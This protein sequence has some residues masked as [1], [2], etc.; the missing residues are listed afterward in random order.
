MDPRLIRLYESGAAGDEVAAILRLG[1]SGVLP[2]GVRAVS[3]FGDIVTVRLRRGAIPPVHAAVASLKPAAPVRREPLSGDGSEKRTRML[4]GDFRRP[5]DDPATGR[6]VVLAS[7][8]WGLDFA[9][10]DFRNP[11]GSTRLLALW[12]QGADGPATGPFGYGRI[13][14]PADINR[15]LAS[16]NAYRTLGYDPS[17]SDIDG[18]GTHGTHVLGIAAGNDRAGGPMGVAPGADLVFVH[19]TTLQQPER[20]VELADSATILEAVDFVR[21]VAGPRPWVINLSMGQTGDQHD[22]TTLTEQGLDAALLEAPGRAITQSTGNYWASGLHHSGRVAPGGRDEVRFS[23]PEDSGAEL[24]VWYRGSDRLLMQLYA[25]GG[26]RAAAAGPGQQSA[27]LA[28]G[29]SVGRIYHR[30]GDPNNSDNHIVVFVDRDAPAGNWTLALSSLHAA[31]GRY[32][33][34]IQRSDDA[35]PSTRFA[36]NDTDPCFTTGSICNGR[37]TIATGAYDAHTDG[38]PLG[39]FSSSGP[40]R[41][42]RPK[43]DLVAPG[44]S[45]L[46]ARSAPDAEAAGRGALVRMSGTSMAAPHVAGTIALMFEAAPRPLRI[47]ETRELLLSAVRTPGLAT[48]RH[49]RGYLNTDEAVRAARRVRGIGMPVSQS[50]SSYQAGPLAVADQL[51][52]LGGAYAASPEALVGSV[53]AGTAGSRSMDELARRSLLSPAALFDSFTTPA[54]AAARPHLTRVFSTVAYPRQR[55]GNPRAGDLLVRRALGEPGVGHIAFV[56]GHRGYSRDEAYRRGMRLE[57]TRPGIYVHVVEAGAY[58]HRFGDRFA[59]RIASP[60]GYVPADTLLL[61]VAAPGGRQ[62]YREADLANAPAIDVNQAVQANDQYAT[63]LGWDSAKGRIDTLLGLSSTAGDSDLARGVA[64][65]QSDHSLNVD[66]ILGPDT[67]TAMQPQLD[68]GNGGAPVAVAQAPPAPPQQQAPVQAPPPQQPAPAQ[69]APAQPG[70]APA[71]APPVARA[72][73]VRQDGMDVAGGRNGN[74]MPAWADIRAAGITFLIHRSSHSQFGIDPDFSARYRDTASNGFIRGSYRYYMHDDAQTGLDQANVVVGLVPRL[75]PGDLA[76]SLDFEGDAL[77]PGSTEPS[78]TDWRTELEAFLDTLETKLGRTPIVYTRVGPWTQHLSGKPDFVAGDFAHFGDYPLWAPMFGMH[79]VNRNFTVTDAAGAAHVFNVRLNPDTAPVETEPDIAIAGAL[80]H[81]L[82]RQAS[83]GWVTEVR[84]QADALWGT[85]QRSSPAA[86]IPPPWG[87]NWAIF[88]YSHHT[89]ARF[90]RFADWNLDFNV[91][92]GGIYFLRGLADLGYTAPHSAGWLDMIVYS[93]PNG[94]VHVLE[95]ML[96]GWTDMTA[97]DISGDPAGTLPAAAGD[98]GAAVSGNE[99][100]VAFRSRDGV[101]HALTRNLA[102]GPAGWQSDDITALGGGPAWGDPLVTADQEGCH[103][104]YWNQDNVQVHAKHVHGAWQVET[105]DDRAAAAPS[106]SLISGYAVPYRFQNALHVA[107]RS[108]DA[109]HLFDFVTGAAP[110][111]LTAAA[112]TAGGTPVPAATFH[113]STYTRTGQAPRIVF[114]ALRGHIWQI[115]RDTMVATDLSAAAGAATPTAMGSPSAVFADTTHIVFRALQ[116][117]IHEIFDDSGTWRARRVCTDTTAVSDPTAFVASDGN[118]AASFRTGTGGIG[119][120]R[121]AN[122]TWT[123]E[124]AR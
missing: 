43:P 103:I 16:R 32:H 18:G 36:K 23:L 113:P 95:K 102:G 59:R 20:D 48:P 109:G 68:A 60:E 55:L 67:W 90:R 84:S 14:G 65:W 93:E 112:H 91:T 8:D 52:G 73:P 78:A 33:C 116:G 74:N 106:P 79:V 53:L 70:P 123:C 24:E 104:F 107:S 41:D 105:F 45:V 76:P 97:D 22:G 77:A 87:T 114:R 17:A 89:P 85:R 25:P 44:V 82:W 119:V 13:H 10:P 61:R 111:D 3:R 122:G 62:M 121:F 100:A 40:T 1:P 28:D 46:S 2:P 80:A 71:P 96:G 11:D 12:D 72:A 66:G 81:A 27:I 26:K 5:L 39:S 54:M 124:D 35:G 4:P 99:Q 115:E 51:I 30:M 58:P 69:P 75:G 83:T 21:R 56:A 86:V 57:S 108:R 15:A 94:V 7:I 64:Q 101:M 110:Q 49:G 6:G 34:W 120:A 38:W 118:A 37:L 117:Q 88:Q 63:Q 31:D 42:G 19:L 47:E 92:N 29:D 98:P 50:R 9:H